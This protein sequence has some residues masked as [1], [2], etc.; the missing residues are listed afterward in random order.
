MLLR[1]WSKPVPSFVLL[2]KRILYVFIITKNVIQY[3]K[4]CLSYFGTDMEFGK[5]NNMQ[6]SLRAINRK[7]LING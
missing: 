3:K 5:K 2:A 7:E 1:D 6:Q 4:F